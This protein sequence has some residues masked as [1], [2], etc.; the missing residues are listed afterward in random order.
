VF[1]QNGATVANSDFYL[2]PVG[3]GETR[4]LGATKLVQTA[5]LGWMPDGKNVYFV[6]NLGDGW[7]VWLSDLTGGAPRSVGDTG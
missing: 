5:A 4:P 2:I 3:A 6:A 7:R 1:A